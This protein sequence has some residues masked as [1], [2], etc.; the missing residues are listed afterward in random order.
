ML[1]L[2]GHRTVVIMLQ[3]VD[4]RTGEATEPPLVSATNLGAELWAM[5]KLRHD[6]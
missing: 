5:E 3:I 2:L 1:T 6:N 4:E